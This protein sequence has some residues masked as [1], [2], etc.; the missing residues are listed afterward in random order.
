[1]GLLRRCID[2][3]PRN[4]EAY[5]SLGFMWADLGQ[6]LDEA[7][8]L[9]RKALTFDPDNGAYIDSLGWL[10]YKRGKY[11][12]ALVELL[13][14]AKKSLPEPDAVVSEHIGDTYPGLEPH[15]RRRALLAEI[16][17]ARSFEQGNLPRRS[18][19]GDCQGIAQKPAK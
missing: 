6:H 11:D 12:D 1:M 4:P 19:A 9:I 17:A 10:Y 18:T 7:E 16:R 15:D 3:D 2:L 8:T 14:A 5:N 13:R